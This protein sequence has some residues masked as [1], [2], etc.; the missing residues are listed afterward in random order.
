[1]S[2]RSLQDAVVYYGRGEAY[3]S[4]KYYKNAIADLTQAIQL[5]PQDYYYSL[6]GKAYEANGQ[7]TE[8]LRD[9]T[10]ANKM[11]DEKH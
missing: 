8:A 2:G 9:Y 6:R 4:K 10:Q 1:M 3:L 11:R 7:R 5:D